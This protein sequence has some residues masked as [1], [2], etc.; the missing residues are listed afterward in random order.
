MIINDIDPTAL[1]LGPLEIRWYGALFSGGFVIGYIIMQW[2]FRRKKYNSEDLD[3]LLVMIFAGTVIGARLAHCLIYEPDYYL[4]NPLEILKVWKGGLASHGG[5]LGVF[6]AVLLFVRW[7]KYSLLELG[8]MLAIPIALVCALIRVG[9]YCNS[10]ILGIP[11]GSDFGVIFAAL[12]ETFPR[13]PVQLF[14]SAAYFAAFIILFVCYLKKDG[15]PRGLNTGLLIFL[16]FTARFFIEPLKLEQADYSTG[17]A[18][19]VGQLLSV[20]A[21]A[22]G[23][24]IIIYAFK[25]AKK[26]PGAAS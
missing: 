25:K 10:E 24:L 20:P 3:L 14:E 11:T 6:L 5:A 9:N 13:Y 17:T 19:T 21:M 1:A 4:G 15:R 18:F 16:C 12:G 22:L 26:E 23:L 8:D 7:H 2:L